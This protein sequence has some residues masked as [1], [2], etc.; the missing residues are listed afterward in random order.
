MNT[1]FPSLSFFNF[2]VYYHAKLQTIMET[3]DFCVKV[4]FCLIVRFFPQSPSYQRHLKTRKNGVHQPF[5][6]TPPS[7]KTLDF[8]PFFNTFACEYPKSYGINSR[9]PPVPLLDYD[10]FYPW[11]KSFTP[12]Y[13]TYEEFTPPYFAIRQIDK[14]TPCLYAESAIK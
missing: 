4:Y 13:P 11:G 5:Q 14:L 12:F 1:P 7:L 10:D 2:S 9:L 6:C 3:P 8:K